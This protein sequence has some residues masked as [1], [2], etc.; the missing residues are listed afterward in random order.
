M[1]FLQGLT[2]TNAC[3]NATKGI[4]PCEYFKNRDQAIKRFP[5]EPLDIEELHKLGKEQ[6]ICPYFA[7]RDRS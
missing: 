7:N 2:L 1:S 5:W 3:K 4:N 6:M